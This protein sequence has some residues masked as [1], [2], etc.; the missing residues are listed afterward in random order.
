MHAHAFCANAGPAAP[1][2]AGG[3][4]R[5]PAAEPAGGL[6]PDAV[7]QSI[8]T[9]ILREEE[10]AAMGRAYQVFVPENGMAP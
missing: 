5:C 6:L 3:A 1:T 9:L 2:G 4:E 10:V 7:A 8:Q